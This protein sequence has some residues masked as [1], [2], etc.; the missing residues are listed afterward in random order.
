MCQFTGLVAVV[1]LLVQLTELRE[2]E[3][4]AI[5]KPNGKKYIESKLIYISEVSN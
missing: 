4:L 3:I 1:Q 2:L 5:F